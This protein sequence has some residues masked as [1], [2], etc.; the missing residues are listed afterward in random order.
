GTATGRTFASSQ[1]RAITCCTA[2][3]LAGFV[4][5]TAI[6]SIERIY[7]K[8]A[9]SAKSFHCA[10]ALP[11]FCGSLL[12]MLCLQNKGPGFHPF[13]FVAHN[14]HHL[15]PVLVNQGQYIYQGTTP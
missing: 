14:L 11:A 9:K 8:D 6:F 7:R 15:Q 12:R 10:F 13:F 3:T 5:P 4:E 1:T 2:R